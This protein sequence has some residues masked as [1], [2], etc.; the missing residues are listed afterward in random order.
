MSEVMAKDALNV[1]CPLHLRLDADGIIMNV[2][3]TLQR[4][5]P[6]FDFIG[7]PVFDV[8]ELERPRGLNGF[9]GLKSRIGSP[10][11][12][13]LPGD[14]GSPFKGV[15][16]KGSYGYVLNLSFGF[17]VAESVANFGLTNAD[18][19]PTDLTIEMLYLIEAKSAAMDESRKLNQR[20][21]GAKIA[22]EEQAFTD[23]LTGLKNRR[24][25]DHILGRLTATRVPF[26]L[27]QMDLDYFKSIND[28]LGH[29][30]G[31]H[32]L[33]E[34]AR[35]L[36]EETRSEDTVARAGGDEFILVFQRAT[37]ADRIHKVAERM[38]A[39][40][41][42]PILFGEHKCQISGSAGSVISLDYAPVS[43]EA[44]MADAD[45]ALYMSKRNG[46]RQHTSY[47]PEMA[48]VDTS[49]PT[50]ERG[51]AHPSAA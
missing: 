48:G 11:H 28:N 22:A 49:V 24:A 39:R 32:V 2:G 29:A 13:R 47:L 46:R 42:E 30:A 10:L 38:I 9:E 34:V 37:K 7:K 19:A 1:L 31:D 17:A 26:A 25:L 21:Q 40:L 16:A 8:F 51:A 45:K 3:P 50:G 27:M 20:L 23:T 14:P 33:Q 18:F 5:R 36:V 4:V 6:D 35:I 43:I 41:E 12:M 44:M 15:L